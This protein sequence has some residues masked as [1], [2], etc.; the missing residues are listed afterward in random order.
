V[1]PS[2]QVSRRTWVVGA[3]ERALAATARDHSDNACVRR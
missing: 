2:A 3:Y 1:Y